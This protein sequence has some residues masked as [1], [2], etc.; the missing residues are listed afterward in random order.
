MNMHRAT[1]IAFAAAGLSIAAGCGGASGHAGL[2]KPAYIKHA[3]AV[4]LKASR[5]EDALAQPASGSQ[6]VAY[7]KRTY[8]IERGVVRRLR[9]L[10]PAPGGAATIDAMLTNV[11]RALAFEPDVASAAISGNQSTI[12]SAEARGAPFL[13]RATTA[14]AAYGFAVCGNS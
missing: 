7:V 11:D 4:C 2:S 12:N 10:A 13:H 14:A 8:A 3:D 1:L 6:R 9:A 5:A